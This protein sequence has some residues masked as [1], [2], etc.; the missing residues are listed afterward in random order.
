MWL[1]ESVCGIDDVPRE[2][3]VL[4][5]WREDSPFYVVLSA[6]VPYR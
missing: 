1:T 5:R 3:C 4:W 6:F 2:T